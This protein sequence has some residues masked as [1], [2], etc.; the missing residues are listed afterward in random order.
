MSDYEVDLDKIFR[1][2]SKARVVAEMLL[3]GK[4][5]SRQDLATKADVSA[6]TIPR[7]IDLLRTKAGVRLET[8]VGETG[9]DSVYRVVGG[10]R[11]LAAAEGGGTFTTSTPVQVRVDRLLLQSGRLYVETGAKR[12]P[13]V[14]NTENV[15]S[16]LVGEALPIS[17]IVMDENGEISLVVT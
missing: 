9:R 3:D 13:L 10:P 6:T 17:T 1:K 11:A 4:A 16:L 8:M 5:H 7:V 12:L 2:G 15:S 14:G